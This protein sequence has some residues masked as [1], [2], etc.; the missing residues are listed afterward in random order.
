MNVRTV[1]SDGKII[2]VVASAYIHET[3]PGSK[4]V[5]S[6]RATDAK[7][8]AVVFHDIY[9]HQIFT[10]PDSLELSPSFEDNI[11]RALPVG[12]YVVEVSVCTVPPK[13]GT[14]ALRDSKVLKNHQ[15]MVASGKLVIKEQAGNNFPFSG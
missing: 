11:A 1:E 14:N 3:R 5:W 13:E 6:V 12:A 4:Y 7:S 9:D 8:K 10:L 2:H 15:Q